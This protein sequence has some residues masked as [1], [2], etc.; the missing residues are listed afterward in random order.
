MTK[1]NTIETIK[2]ETI[3]QIMRNLKDNPD[4]YNHGSNQNFDRFDRDD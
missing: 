1:I 4:Y 3:D 2:L